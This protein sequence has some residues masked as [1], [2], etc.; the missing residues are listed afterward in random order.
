MTENENK[1]KMQYLKNV[2]DTEDRFGQLVG[3]KITKLEDGYCEGE[4]VLEEKHLN[5][6]HTVHGGCLY[7][8]ADTV[9]GMAASA[10]SVKDDGS[11]MPGPTISGNMYF[12][13]PTMGAKKL[14]CKGTVI[15]DGKRVRVAETNIYSDNGKL[16]AKCILEYMV[17]QKDLHKGQ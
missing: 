4:L 15:K 17:S 1:E 9:G 16:V 11:R 13:R 7:T 12:M 5:P 14:I 2:E 3:L 6:L 10:C 8:L